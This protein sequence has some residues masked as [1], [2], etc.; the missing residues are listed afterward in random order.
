MAA[1]SQLTVADDSTDL[2]KEYR[3]IRQALINAGLMTS[4]LDGLYGDWQRWRDEAKSRA[5]QRANAIAVDADQW[6]ARHL[7]QFRSLMDPAH[8]AARTVREQKDAA[9]E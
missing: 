9:Q 7:S 3:T 4:N 6:W 8:L 2:E 1:I 5:A